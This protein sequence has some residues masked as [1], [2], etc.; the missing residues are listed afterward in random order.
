M[1][2][3]TDA[4]SITNPVEL[5]FSFS[6][7]SDGDEDIS[8]FTET[9]C[10]SAL[11]G[12]TSMPEMR[13]DADCISAITG[14]TSIPE[15]HDEEEDGDGGFPRVKNRK[16]KS[17]HRPATTDASMME[18]SAI[19]F[20]SNGSVEASL[21]DGM[22]GKKNMSTIPMKQQQRAPLGQ[23]PAKAV[24]FSSPGN[25]FDGP[26]S[27]RSALKSK[28]PGRSSPSNASL[29]SVQKKRAPV[30]PLSDPGMEDKDEDITWEED[31]N[32]DINP[33]LL[34]I[35]LQRGD[36]KDCTDYLDG[37]E[38]DLEKPEKDP[39]DVELGDVLGFDKLKSFLG[40]VTEAARGQ[41]GC[42]I[43]KSKPDLAIM[44]TR[45]K[46]LRTQARTWIVRRER[47]GVLRWRILPLHAALVFSAPFDIVLRLYHLYPGAVRCRNDMGMLPLHHVFH[48]G[49]EDRVLELFLS[50]FPEALTV[51]DD[52]GRLPLGCTPEDGSDNERRSNILDLY[53]K[54]QV[55][56]VKNGGV[57]GILRKPQ[58]Q[59]APPPV[60]TPAPPSAPESA[61]G[62]A[63][64]YKNSTSEYSPV[65]YDAL[66][67][68]QHSQQ[69]TLQ[70]PGNAAAP[71]KAATPQVNDDDN[72]PI[73]A[74]KYAS[75]N[76]SENNPMNGNK[77]L[78]GLDAIPEEGDESGKKSRKVLRR[79]FK[80]K[81]VI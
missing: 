42:G 23:L 63:P 60:N 55:T 10:M 52:K 37:K 30:P 48:Y 7:E 29:T 49:S 3:I 31:C 33:T 79:L 65:T 57:L 17:Y 21:M 46:D 35:L 68:P 41:Y 58:H 75:M 40:E 14:F 47:T 6:N 62:I 81:A 69:K 76:D 80:K 70:Q 50:V 54:F 73:A 44:K 45:Q 72:S 2:Y 56:L 39:L 11:T 43:L 22:P 59:Q 64:R 67:R 4:S 53:C 74:D 61:L 12:F 71:T 28:T 34:Y 78:G 15:M 24:Q 25:S 18:V 13:D 51:L 38:V 16:K 19:S 8:Y 77:L 27:P 9:E 36:W 20:E 26:A 5:G 66:A 32:Y 1:S